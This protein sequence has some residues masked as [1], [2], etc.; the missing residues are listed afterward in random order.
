MEAEAYLIKENILVLSISV[1]IYNA[2]V[3]SSAKRGLLGLVK[4]STLKRIKNNP[5][6]NITL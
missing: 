4:R 6:P 3:K 5:R 2:T 1:W